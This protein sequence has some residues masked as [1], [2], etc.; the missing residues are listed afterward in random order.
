MIPDLQCPYSTGIK[1]TSVNLLNE[2]QLYC[3]RFYL[4]HFASFVPSKSADLV[5]QELAA[6]EHVNLPM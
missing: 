2:W 5:A 6:C 4:V 1:L 3:T